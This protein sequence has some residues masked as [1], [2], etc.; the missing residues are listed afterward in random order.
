MSYDL[1]TRWMEL[2]SVEIE[3]AL[4]RELWGK[5]RLSVLDMSSFKCLLYFQVEVLSSCLPCM[6][7]DLRSEIWTGDVI[8]L[9]QYMDI[10]KV[11]T[12]DNINTGT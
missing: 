1:R 3:N 7:L 8:R 6:N 11:M 9:S 2:L 10:L 5:K 4:G 12:L